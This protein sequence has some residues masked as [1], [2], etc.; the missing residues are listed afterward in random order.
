LTLAPGTRLGPYEIL[1]PLGA[2]GMGEV[3]R[4]RDPRLSREVAIKVLPETLS[5]NSERLARFRREAQMLA[6]LNHSQIAAIYGLEEAGRAEALVLELV[7]G[8]TL[9]ERIARG[10]VPLEEALPLAR[11]IAE[12]LEYAHERGIVHRDLKPANVKVTPEGKVKILDFGLAKALETGGGNPDVSSSP[13]LTGAATQAGVVIGTAAYM[14]P[15]QARGKTVDKR[16]DVWA[17]G[18]VLYEMLSGRKAFEGENVTDTLAS[19]VR[20]EPD[21]KALPRS[22]PPALQRLLERCLAK[23]AT[24][25]LQ[26]IGDARIELEELCAAQRPASSTGAPRIVERRRPSRRVGWVALGVV[27]LVAALVALWHRMP[28]RPTPAKGSPAPASAPVSAERSLAVLPFR[29]LSGDRANDYFSDGISEEILNALTRLPGLKVI[30][31]TSSFRFRGPDVDASAVGKQLGVGTILSGSVQK[32]GDAVRVTAELVDTGTGYQLWS[33]KYDRKLQNLF[34]LE[35]EIS[36]SIADALRVQLAGGAAQ[37]LVSAATTSPEAH[38]LFLRAKAAALHSD[39]SSLTEAVRLFQEAVAL[40]PHYAAAWSGM[41]DAYNYLGDAYRSPRELAPLA[42]Q[43]AERA[44]A[45]DPSFAGGHSG[46]GITDFVWDWNFPAAHREFERALALDPAA[47]LT[48]SN[49]GLM[50]AT[51]DGDIARSRSENERAARQDPLNPFIPYNQVL[52]EI[53]QRNYAEALRYATRIREIDPNFLYFIDATA[54]VQ[55]AMG[56]W[57]DCVREQR[58]LPE[59]LRPQ[60]Q[61]GLAICMAHSG[62]EKEAREILGRLEQESR[63]RYVDG[64]TIG[65]IYA[66]L[67]QKD[68]AFAWIDKA[69]EAHSGRMPM[70]ELWPDLEPLR[71]D[72]RF[73]RLVFRIGVKGRAR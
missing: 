66:A 13:T 63:H 53:G 10:P 70:L 67:G 54:M 14:S 31:R 2:G 46:L 59:A 26:A 8:E 47:G 58:E 65:S 56:R 52:V 29:N 57:G 45:V 50:L 40:D 7:E 62:G 15:E 18:C 20:D 49:Y 69:V 11:Q 43:A 36:R 16:T 23:E 28:P 21:W 68:E 33:Q 25:R 1:S 9:A 61:I 34:E 32:A 6:A 19:L 3:Y 60:S 41:C 22:T 24:R 72:P 64:S 51:V 30:G 27:V 42:R 39:E 12:G 71:S 5:S 73:D 55:M 17:F 35:D 44:I 48:R 4:A 37:P 38:N